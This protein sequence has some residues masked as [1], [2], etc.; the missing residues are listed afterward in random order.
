[1]RQLSVFSII[2]FALCL[3]AST[4]TLGSGN[5]SDQARPFVCETTLGEATLTSEGVEQL[6]FSR[7]KIQKHCLMCDGE[8]CS[9]KVWPE[10]AKNENALCASLFCIPKATH[11]LSMNRTSS[12][13]E[14]EARVFF[15]ITE[16]GRGLLTRVKF[17]SP[18]GSMT[19]AKK[20]TRRAIREQ[21][22]HSVFVPATIDGVPT[23]ITNLSYKLGARTLDESAIRVLETPMLEDDPLG[24][25]LKKY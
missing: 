3:I 5:A 25:M 10:K 4:Q 13:I 20:Q 12:S 17:T 7:S 9:M 24:R 18:S 16:E 2:T 11:R 6:L 22:A 8:Q 19:P 21:L 23:K 15:E 14:H 1:M